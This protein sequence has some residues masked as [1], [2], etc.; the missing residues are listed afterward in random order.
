MDWRVELNGLLGPRTRTTRAEREDAMF[1]DFLR[2][3]V[4]PA[5]ALISEEL[6]KYERE[7]AIRTTTASTSLNVRNE[8][9]EEFSFRVLRR[10]LPTMTVPYAEFRYREKNGFRIARS[11]TIF[12]ESNAEGSLD[13]VTVD[14]IVETFLKCYRNSFEG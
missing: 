1:Q 10:S 14:D 7:T 5:F 6:S 8:G 12:R 4:H 9:E 2:E 13:K 3:V 11:E